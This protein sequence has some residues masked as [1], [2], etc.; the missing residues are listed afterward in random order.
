MPTPVQS[1][2]PQQF[3]GI[4]MRRKRRPMVDY[5][6]SVRLAPKAKAASKPQRPYKPDPVIGKEHPHG[7]QPPKTEHLTNRAAGGQAK[8]D[9]PKTAAPKPNQARQRGER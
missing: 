3:R 5:R 2:D 8:V 1:I 4:P 6:D 9:H 7:K